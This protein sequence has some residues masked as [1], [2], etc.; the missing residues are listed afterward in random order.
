MPVTADTETLFRQAPKTA[1]D[2]MRNAIHDIDEIFGAGY[3]KKNP[4]LVGAYIQTCALDFG[5]AVITRAL[6]GK[7]E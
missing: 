6:E 2:Y 1:H 4:V 5:A 3:A 7:I